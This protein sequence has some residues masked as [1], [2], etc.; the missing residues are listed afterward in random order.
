MK[1]IALSFLFLVLG[2]TSMRAQ[3]NPNDYFITLDKDMSPVSDQ[4]KAA[5]F[6]H[7]FKTP[8]G[9]WQLD[10]YNYTGPR[11]STES[12]KDEE[13]QIPHGFFAYYN[14]NGTLDSCGNVYEKRK[15]GRRTYYD[16]A[17]G[18]V[19]QTKEY[20][21]GIHI[22]TQQFDLNKKEDSTEEKEKN[23][24]LFLKVEIESEFPGG[25]NAWSRYLNKKLEYPTRAYDLRK[26]GMVSILFIVDKE[27]RVTEPVLAQSVEYSLDEEALRIIRSSPKWTP[28]IQD[29]RQVKSYKKQP[30]IFKMQ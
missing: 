18:K 5:Y 24:N 2:T 13:M 6:I 20:D 23:N 28:A 4:K 3:I 7:V 17:T 1:K 12:F 19:F 29:G 27:G 16:A 26:E 15:D 22:R 25:I 10:H 14:A 21:K 30:I 8:E 9:L 11:K